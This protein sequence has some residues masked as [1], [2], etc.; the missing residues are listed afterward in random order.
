MTG[1]TGNIQGSVKFYCLKT[2]K[3]LKRRLFTPLPMPDQVI[4]RVNAIGAREKQG[5]EFW[6]LNQRKEPYEWTD[7][8]PEDDP[9]FQG[10][11][12][13]TAQYPDI[14]AKLP[15]V[16]LEREIEDNQVVTDE[17]E[18]DFAELVAAALEN[19]G[20]DPQDRL[21]SAQAAVDAPPGLFQVLATVET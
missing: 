3:I 5:Q 10:L 18:S 9:K 13:E 4:K 16:E 2:G 7:K 8:V 1:L 14:P 20:I 19:A 17:P 21:R 6:F 15:G 12:E 11:L